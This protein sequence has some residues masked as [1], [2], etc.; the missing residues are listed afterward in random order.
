MTAYLHMKPG[1]VTV[2]V[3]DTVNQGDKIG[4]VGTTG[5]STGYHLLLQFMMFLEQLWIL[6]II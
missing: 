4:E 5:A 1:S 2:N 3:G 6:M